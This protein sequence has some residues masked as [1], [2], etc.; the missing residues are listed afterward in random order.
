MLRYLNSKSKV[1]LMRFFSL[2]SKSMHS[3]EEF[4]YDTDR[5]YLSRTVLLTVMIP[6]S[7][8]VA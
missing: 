4:G 5:N 2:K 1:I 6:K 3:L 8:T 7:Q